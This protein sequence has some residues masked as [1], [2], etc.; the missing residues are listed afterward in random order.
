MATYYIDPENHTGT[1]SDTAGGG[2]STLNPYLN[3]SYAVNDVNVTH[4]KNSASVI[5]RDIFKMIGVF[6]PN[7][8]EI[9]AVTSAI[10]AYG[11]GF[12]LQSDGATEFGTQSPTSRSTFDYANATITLGT[13]NHQ[14]ANYHGFNFINGISGVN[15]ITAGSYSTYS[16]CFFDLENVAT[17]PKAAYGRTLYK[18]TN[19]YVKARPTGNASAVFDT[20][21]YHTISDSFF[22]LAYDSSV[23]GVIGTGLCATG[24]NASNNFLGNICLLNNG[25]NAVGANSN[26]HMVGNIIIGSDP[27]NKT[28]MAINLQNF[29]GNSKV[30][31]NHFENLHNVVGSATNGTGVYDT[32]WG[33]EISNN[34]YFN[35]NYIDTPDPNYTR[36]WILDSAVVL[37][38]TDLGLS[39]VQDIASSDLRT[40]QNRLGVGGLNSM[41]LPM[42]WAESI[43]NGPSIQGNIMARRLRDIY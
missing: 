31:G 37:N 35:V 34:T 38:N 19:C 13:I 5:A 10:T 36:N 21:S 33:V 18:V 32:S 25:A 11:N 43:A 6:Q 26:V 42:A 30:I 7:D 24:A 17:Y 23:V 41:N 16:N 15:F 28:C 40:A 14:Y 9:T 20:Y 2:T 39:G 22:D 12:T 3:L 4:G 29:S 8:A 1:A 27:S